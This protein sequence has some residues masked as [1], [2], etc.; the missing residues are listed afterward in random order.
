[1]AE[2][3]LQKILAQAGY[4]SRRSS[5]EL[6]IAGRV[7]VNGK[8][9]ELGMK[10]DPERDSIAVDGRLLPRMTAKKLY[11]ALH[12]PR[13]VLSVNAP[14]DNRPTVFDLMPDQGHL[15]V[16]GR[17]DFD[18]EGLMILTNDGDLAN[19][20]THPR[21][22]HEKEY[23][24]LVGKKPDDDQLAALRHGVVLE[25]GRRTAPAKVIVEQSSP[26]GTWLRMT[27]REGRKRQ[28]REMGK[29][30]GMPVLR[31]L[32]VRIGTLEL[33]DLKPGQ[34]RQLTRE[35]VGELQESAPSVPAGK[36][37]A[38]GPGASRPARRPGAR[39]PKK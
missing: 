32:R 30:I 12:K 24:V 15:F 9:A 3:R 36:S 28:I 17:L 19:R 20:L 33:G 39:P 14:Q 11:F 6:I 34:W 23:R 38:K 22:G 1:M 18:S 35:E 31:I 37:R 2:E 27:L 5:E 8:V 29:Q 7:K 16:V 13:G 25:D 21:Y 26:K 10:A 4:G